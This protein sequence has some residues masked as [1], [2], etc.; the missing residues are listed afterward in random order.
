MK[1]KKIYIIL[2]IFL[3]FI[4]VFVGIANYIDTARVTTGHEPKFC[5][6]VIAQDGSKVTYWGL[7]YKVIRYV[8]VSP[9]EP[10]ENNIGAKMGNWWMQYDLP[11]GKYSIVE[12]NGKTIEITNNDDVAILENI[13]V[14]SK[15]DL[16]LCDG[17]NTYKI[18]LN[19]EIYYIK[20]ACMEIQK[21]DKQAGITEQD[22]NTILKII[23]NYE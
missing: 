20:E 10:Y 23:E 12:Y 14:N 1:N 19:H 6:K 9:D 3:I 17:I 21:G 15:Y 13:L 18:T 22:L 5:I 16:G 7:G 8:G 4:I 11:V 2:A